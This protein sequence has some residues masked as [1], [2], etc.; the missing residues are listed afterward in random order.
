MLSVALRSFLALAAIAFCLGSSV[1]Q[2]DVQLT[3]CG[4]IG[5]SFVFSR[6]LPSYLSHYC[7]SGLYTLRRH[8]VAKSA[9][10]RVPRHFQIPLYGND[11][12]SYSLVVAQGTGLGNTLG[13]WKW[14]IATKSMQGLEG[15]L[16]Y[17]DNTGSTLRTMRV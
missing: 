14:A 1:V 12:V 9:G 2:G 3:V 11:Y 7:R 8:S 4:P 17:W 6:E 10:V 13:L 16:N 5:S 15:F